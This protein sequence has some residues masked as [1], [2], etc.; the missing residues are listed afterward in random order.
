MKTP[1]AHKP[2]LLPLSTCETRSLSRE[3][4]GVPAGR[5]RRGVRLMVTR[6]APFSPPCR[7]WEPKARKGEKRAPPAPSTIMSPSR[8]RRQRVC[9]RGWVGGPPRSARVCRIGP[10]G[11]GG[12]RISD[13]LLAYPPYVGAVA[14]L[15]LPPTIAICCTSCSATALFTVNSTRSP[16]SP[17]A[18]F[19]S[20]KNGHFFGH[21]HK[22]KSNMFK[23]WCHDWLLKLSQRRRLLRDGILSGIRL[24]AFLGYLLNLACQHWMCNDLVDYLE[25]RARSVV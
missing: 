20:P 19:T 24:S 8:P 22:L 2:V 7:G 5:S 9:S 11:R 12:V 10:A 25:Q 1:K 21:T 4:E 16:T 17:R 3:G 13:H 18:L 23:L 14:V 15:Y 6:P